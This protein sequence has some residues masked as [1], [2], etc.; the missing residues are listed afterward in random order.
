MTKPQNTP[1]LHTYIWEGINQ[2]GERIRGEN[3]ALNPLI[4][5]AELR[6]Q[7]ITPKRVRKKS[8]SFFFSLRKK[9]HPKEVTLFIRQMATMLTAGI[10]IVQAV[11][12]I[13]RG[14]TNPVFQQLLLTIKTNIETGTPPSEAFRKHPK[15]FNALLCN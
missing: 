12:L 10:P 3:N 14:Q 1:Q 7:G 15:I 2:Q 5:K 13:A 9:I 4:L 6:R 8:R 11:D